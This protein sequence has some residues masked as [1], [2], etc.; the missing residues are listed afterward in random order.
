M[1]LK[2]VLT[3]SGKTLFTLKAGQILLSLLMIGVILI[4]IVWSFASYQT[5][6]TT[7]ETILAEESDSSALVF[8]QRE[9]FGLIIELEEFQLGQNSE[10][11]LLLARSTLAQRLNVMTS[12]GK[13]TY[14]VSG[15]EFRSALENLDEV[16]LSSELLS[17]VERV[18]LATEEFLTQTRLLTD[19]FQDISRKNVQDA[20]ADRA[21]IDLWQGALSLLALALGFWVTVWIVR[22]I[23]MGF[24]TG[25][26][27]LEARLK[28][29]EQARSDFLSIQM[30]DE[31]VSTWNAQLEAGA[32]PSQV[33]AEVNQALGRLSAQSDLSLTDTGELRFGQEFLE[34]SDSA[35]VKRL[36]QTRLK[37]L[38]GHI[39]RQNK[40]R[41]QLEWERSHDSLTGLLNRRGMA[42]R[43][44]EA[45]SAG[46][47]AALLVEIDIDGF[48][49]FNNSMGHSVGDELLREI[50]DRLKKLEISGAQIG[51]VAADE[52]AMVINLGKQNPDELVQKIEGATRH[53]SRLGG[54]PVSISACIGWY[55]VD[56]GQTAEEA[57]A[58]AGAALKAAKTAGTLGAV[59]KFAPEE[60]SH[61]LTDYLEQIRFRNALLNG[62]LIPFLQPIV[63][64]ETRAVEGYEVLARWDKPGVGIVSPA[65]FIPL[66]TQGGLLDELFQVMLDNVASKWPSVS[67][68]N[69][70][71]YFAINVD[72]KTLEMTDFAELVLQGLR[73]NNVSPENLV[74]EITEQSLVDDLRVGELNTLR[75]AGIRIAL[76][77]FGTGYSSLSRL[78]ALPI[79]ILKVDRSFISGGISGQ[80]G[81]MLQTIKEMAAGAALRVVVEGIEDEDVAQGLLALGFQSGQGYLFGKPAGI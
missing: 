13:S 30:L 33:V 23:T 29:L 64:L 9:S 71:A 25:Y 72:P 7:R 70:S 5:H 59:R 14:E 36:L 31:Q 55:L 20:I 3:P 47:Q 27:E 53:V 24:R 22:D 46:N 21:L 52:F 12:G 60:H 28:D 81:A 62:E 69:G 17:D 26:R 56:A 10:E 32:A 42:S 58:K 48:T 74:L 79:D 6:D 50:A 65:D 8:V 37:E 67:S 1:L 43:L 80:P 35:E 77:D 45:L 76:D 41:E 49:G 4:L 2:P 63:S 61:L 16:I 54:A 39:Q 44:V 75:R 19:V 73:R 40:A 57:A 18:G 51:R 68:G 78:A 38:M 66:A 11:D 34:G 15:P